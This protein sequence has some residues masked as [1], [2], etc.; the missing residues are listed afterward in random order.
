MR[1]KEST[2]RPQRL[3]TASID[4]VDVAELQEAAVSN[5]KGTLCTDRVDS[6]AFAFTDQGDVDAVAAQA[7]HRHRERR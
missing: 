7:D 1:W 4:D 6:G 5:V 3:H 2:F